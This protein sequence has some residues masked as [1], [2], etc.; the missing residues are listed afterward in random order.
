M[1]GA[2]ALWGLAF[3]GCATLFQTAS[4]KTA[5]PAADLAQSM[6]V[7]AW[8]TAIAGGGMIGGVLLDQFGVGAFAPTMIALLIICF[9]V[10][11]NARRHGF[12]A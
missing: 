10:T 2:T 1:Y 12:T 11:L 4:A 3:G 7:T 9:T 5:G 8:N 6:L